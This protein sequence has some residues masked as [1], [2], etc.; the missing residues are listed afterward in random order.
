MVVVPCECGDHCFRKLNKGYVTIFDPEDV[1]LA[2]RGS[3]WVR[4]V[5]RHTVYV[6]HQR[7]IGIGQS[8]NFRFHRE[9]MNASPD[10]QID[11][12]SGNGLDNRK[13]NLRNA[14]RSQNQRNKHPRD[15][16]TS[17]YMG[18]SWDKKKRKWR[19]TIQADKQVTHIG[20]FIS[21]IDAAIAYDNYAAVLHGEFA[22]FN[23]PNKR[24]AAS[25]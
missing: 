11:H 10:T 6:I 1:K 14:T 16:C 3:F 7:Y 19:A 21:E 8:K 15:N 25:G 23:F 17:K 9:I 5:N 22:R 20:S 4:V 2:S 24:T 13:R 18:V 12:R